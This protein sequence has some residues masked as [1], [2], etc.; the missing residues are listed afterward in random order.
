MVHTLN[1]V[2]PPSGNSKSSIHEYVMLAPMCLSIMSATRLRHTGIFSHRTAESGYHFIISDIMLS[3][4]FSLMSTVSN[5]WARY[6]VGIHIYAHVLHTMKP[7]SSVD[8]YSVRPA[9]TELLQVFGY[10]R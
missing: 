9:R 2:T 3:K 7:E 1:L 6:W 5:Y 10:Y 8:P 4:Y